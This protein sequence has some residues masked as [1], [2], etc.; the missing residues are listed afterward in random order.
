MR[1]RFFG[2]VAIISRVMKALVALKFNALKVMTWIKKNA[3][4]YINRAHVPRSVRR[5][6]VSATRRQNN[7][8][9]RVY[10]AR[11]VKWS[12]R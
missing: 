5:E 12:E 9:F 8:V 10:N 4:V 2:V 3:I 11:R 1:Q 6:V 7:G